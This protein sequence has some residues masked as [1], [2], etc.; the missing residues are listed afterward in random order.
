MNVKTPGADAEGVVGFMLRLRGHGI[1][2]PRLLK[3]V[4][5]VPHQQFLPVE[6]YEK[7]WRSSA[8]PIACG[9]TMIPLDTTLRMIAALGVEPSHSVLEIGTGT[10]YQTALL[11]LLSKKVHSVDRYKSLISGARQRLER[12]DIS[13]VTFEQT[14][15][16]QGTKGQGLYDRVICDLAYEEMP[17]GLLEELVSGG[18]VVTALGPAL[19]EQMVVKLT[20]IGSRFEREDLF[21]VR[22]GAFEDGVAASL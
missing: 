21:P 4:E 19:E 2:D 13:N 20:K 11:A 9:Q 8:M 5:T 18:V 14:D 15:A 1:S 22:F 17:R 6:H 16:N 7:A 3:A 12:L 10:G